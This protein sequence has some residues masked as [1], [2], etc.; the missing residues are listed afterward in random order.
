MNWIVVVAVDQLHIYTCCINYKIS[1]IS[2]KRMKQKGGRE[3]DL[4][5]NQSSLLWSC[6]MEVGHPLEHPGGIS[7]WLTPKRLQTEEAASVTSPLNFLHHS[8]EANLDNTKATLIQGDLLPSQLL[9]QSCCH[10]EIR[11]HSRGQMSNARESEHWALWF[12]HYS[13]LCFWTIA[14]NWTI[15]LI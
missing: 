8:S 1:N 5:Q 15:I 4:V 7:W 12:F 2:L 10:D 9:S 11:L 6:H 3:G 13:M 14:L